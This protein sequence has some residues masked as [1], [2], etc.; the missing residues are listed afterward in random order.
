MAIFRFLSVTILCI[1]LLSPLIRTIFR[2]VEKPI[3][4]IMQDESASIVTIKDST[5]FL[6]SYP[7]AI[8]ELKKSLESDFD[9]RMF[10]IGDKVT[11]GINFNFSDKETDLAGPVDEM[12][13]R[14]SGRNL[15]AVILASDG[16][17]NK[18]RNPLYAFPELKIP[19]FTIGLG[20]TSVRK[21]VLI[22]RVN[23]NKTSFFG[24]TFPVELT[25]DARHCAGVDLVLSITKNGKEIIKKPIKV[26]SDR[27]NVI[28]PVFLEAN[29][30]GMNHY[31]AEVTRVDNEINF[32]N[33]K[34]DFFVE[35]SDNRQQIILLASSPHPDLAAIRDIIESNPNIQLKTVMIDDFDG[36]IGNANL[37]ILHQIPSTTKPFSELFEKLKLQNI[38]V[39]FIL[40][41]QTN[42]ASFNALKV[43]IKISENRGNVNEVQ[44]NPQTD[45]SLF[46]MDEENLRRISEFPP[47]ISPF[48]TYETTGKVYSLLTQKIGTVK[49]GMPLLVFSVDGE[50]KTAIL[51]GEGFWKW[52]LKEFAEHGNS[53]ASTTLLT[54]TIQY[55]ATREKLTP[56]R[57]FYKNTYFENEPLLIDAEFYNES[58][59]LVNLADV[60]ISIT[61]ENKKSFPF[62][63]SKTEKA[64]SL[65]AGYLPVGSYKFTA[66]TTSNN[67]NYS[68]TG[69]FTISALQAELSE[70]IANH[71]LLHALSDRTGG[72][73][74]LPN[75][76]AEIAK[77]IAARNDIKAVSY[78]QKRL[79]DVINLKWIFALIILLLAGEWF[80]RKR[81][82]GY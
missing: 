35:V 51:A 72:K 41:S 67:K 21:D 1:L 31:I 27:F 5:N 2:E 32:Q 48:G 63:F 56:F 80:M 40:G 49:T 6:Q 19:V 53:E 3:V 66:S 13:A 65:N 71:Q 74:F 17:Y 16:L 78:T 26:T 50:F 75:N 36:N 33:N 25:V 10:S 8:N 64:Y 24:N 79:D 57:L 73:F 52:K 37:V 23:H 38:P 46:T 20:D 18:G 4:L 82:G 39:L 59:E 28:L 42:V 47:L 69:S 81:S 44:A 58:G 54:K 14:Y 45:F 43:G 77:E 15:G 55:L 68:E 70:T 30:K 22:S 61:D 62:A 29:E 9:V 7:S 76:I 34:R 12:R 11:D 60:T